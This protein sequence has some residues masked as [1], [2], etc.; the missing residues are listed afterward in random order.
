[1]QHSSTSLLLLVGFVVAM[2]F[3]LLRTLRGSPR[4]ALPYRSKPLLTAWERKVLPLLLEQLSP[5]CHL[6]PQVRLA[7]LLVVTTNDPSARASA[8]NRVTRKSVDFA[9]VDI[10]TGAVPLL[11]ELAANTHP[12]PP[13]QNRAP[14][15]RDILPGA[16]LPLARF[17][18]RQLIDLRLHLVGHSAR[19]T[20]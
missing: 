4:A 1:M 5:G 17:R 8:L 13:R 7:D 6:C 14:D 2:V 18:P 20:Q 15:G 9:I 3:L 10:T 16:P 12:R 11:I 19:H